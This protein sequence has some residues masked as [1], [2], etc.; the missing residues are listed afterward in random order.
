MS[1]PLMEEVEAASH[2]QLGRWCRFLPSPGMSGINLDDFE[3]VMAG[4]T[5]ILNRIIA[6]FDLLGGW[7]P[8]LSKRVG[9]EGS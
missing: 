8:K 4:E 6:R 1:Y 2:E 7:N 5:K 3:L 9:H